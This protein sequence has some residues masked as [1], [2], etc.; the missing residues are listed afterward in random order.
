[1]KT[2]DKKEHEKILERFWEEMTQEFFKIEVLQDYTG[3]DDGPSLQE[4]KKGNKKKSLELLKTDYVRDE[5]FEWANSKKG[6]KKTRVHIVEKPY[7]PYLEWEIEGYKRFN[8][9]YVGEDVF[10]LDKE[11]TGSIWLPEGDML[12]FDQKRA[13]SNHYDKNGKCIGADIYDEKDD[14]YK[15]LELKEALLKM[16][17]EKVE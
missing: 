12:I 13:I 4:W 6:I 16:P 11:L 17:L 15:F 8:I 2:V 14:I 10:L 7:T 1:M 9:P 3:V 5:F